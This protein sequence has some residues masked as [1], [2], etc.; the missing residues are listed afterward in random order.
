MIFVTGGTGLVGAHL[1]YQ[2]SKSGEKV[3]AL[4]RPTSNTGITRDIFRI[5][6]RGDDTL[7]SSIEWVDGDL[8]FYPDIRELISDA[9]AVY[10]C[11]AFVSFNP[12]DK[13]KMIHD[14]ILATSVIVNALLDQ[15]KAKLC[16]VSSTSAL[17]A[18]AN[19]GEVTEECLWKPSRNTSSYSRSKFKSEMEVWR[20]ITEGLNAVIVNPSVI[21]GPGNWGKSSTG[22]F[23]S[24]WNGMRFY[25]NGVTGYVDVNDVVD[26]M[27]KLTNMDI[28]GERFIVSA[29]NRTYQDIFTMIAEALGKKPPSIKASPLMASVAWRLDWLKSRILFTAPT[30]TRE[31]AHAGFG[32]VFFSSNKIREATGISFRPVEDSV[33]ETA[34]YFKDYYLCR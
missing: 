9:D 30:L 16:Y 14:N 18:P 12:A 27:I 25:T 15:G 22:L 3:R 2:L 6:S 24:V 1:L 13:Y 26:S 19:G 31:T 7:F 5:Y 10:H 21:I 32:R 20:G 33:K 17:G 8:L 23:T 28:S 34:G 11:A 29:E 4:K